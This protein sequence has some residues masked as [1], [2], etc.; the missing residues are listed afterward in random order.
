ML[1]FFVFLCIGIIFW[2]F[3]FLKTYGSVCNLDF[4]FLFY[5]SIFQSV[6]VINKVSDVFMYTCINIKL[7]RYLLSILNWIIAADSSLYNSKQSSN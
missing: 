3:S 4:L 2:I 6:S 7:L 5:E 1:V